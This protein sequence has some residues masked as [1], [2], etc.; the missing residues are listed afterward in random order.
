M[1]RY[2]ILLI[3]VAAVLGVFLTYRAA[4]TTT[5]LV[6]TP[7]ELLQEAKTASSNSRL[8]RIRV[9]GR[10][11]AEEIDYQVKPNLKLEF[12][13]SDPKTGEGRLPVLYRGIK[14][15][16]FAPGRDVIIDGSYEG[17]TLLASNLLTQCPSKYEPPTPE[18]GDT[19]SKKEATE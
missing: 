3:V 2:F 13:I 8:S 12:T 15:D 18:A 16:M 9:A 19:A 10:V 7:T 4:Q 11:V 6:F 5:S 1:N 17:G 14:P